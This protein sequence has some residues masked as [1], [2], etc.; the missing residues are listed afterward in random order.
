MRLQ[1]QAE[2]L[3]AS[4]VYEPQHLVPAERALVSEAGMLG[5]DGNGWVVDAHHAGHPRARGGGRRALSLGFSGHYEAME[6]RFDAAPL[7]IAGENIVVE[8]PPLRLPDIADGF[9]VRRRDGTEFALLRPGVA[10]PCAEFTSYL[11]GYDG[12]RARDEIAEELRFLDDGTRGFILAVDH[13]A[14]FEEIRV[15]DELLLAPPPA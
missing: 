15:G 7:G 14:G 6:H 8:G 11:L 12:P 3:K 1:V 9:V 13:L 10:A 5:W 4:G 2:P